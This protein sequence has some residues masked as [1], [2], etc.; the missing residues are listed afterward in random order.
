MRR[1]ISRALSSRSQTPSRSAMA[2]S[3]MVA[4]DDRAPSTPPIETREVG[5]E[6]AR[7]RRSPRIVVSPSAASPVAAW[8]SQA[9]ASRTVA[10][11]AVRRR[12]ARICIIQKAW[13]R[14]M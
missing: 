2:T 12:E 8:P 14:L 3:R 6:R 4:S 7:D 5:V 9:S 1:Q 11:A 10:T 13:P